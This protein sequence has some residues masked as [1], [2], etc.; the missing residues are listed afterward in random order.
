MLTTKTVTAAAIV[1]LTLVRSSAAEDLRLLDAVK[2]QDE[3]GVRLLIKEHV[4]SEARQSDGTT[5]LHWAAH[6]NN[7][8]IALALL[9]AGATVNVANELGVTP[10]VLAG[11]NGNGD[12]VAA[13]LE[14]GA[15]PN[16]LTLAGESPLMAAARSGSVPAVAA[17]LKR[18]ANP[19]A[20]ERTRGQTA[21]M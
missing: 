1:L 4:D 15:N 5:A 20:A 21:L 9:R 19:N 7:L 14:A 16:V 17:L 11:E 10:L 18:G 12:M 13:F 6:R 3:A 8:G 2:R